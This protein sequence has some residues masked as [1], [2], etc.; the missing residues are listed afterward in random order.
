MGGFPRV[1]MEDQSMGGYGLQRM[2]W[3]GRA[4]LERAPFLCFALSLSLSL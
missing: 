4:K 1:C 2:K 3:A